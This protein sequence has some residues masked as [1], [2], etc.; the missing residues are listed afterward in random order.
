MSILIKLEGIEKEY[1]SFGIRTKVLKGINLTIRKGE[2][3]SIMGV[4]GSGKTTL[5]NIIGCLDTPTS[6][7]YFFEG[8]DVSDLDDDRLSEIRNEYIGFVF[9]QFYL[10]NYLTVLENVIVPTIYSKNHRENP[11]DRAKELLEKVGLK[12]KLS[13]KPNQLS[14]GQQQRV[15]IAR[16]LIND[17]DLILADEPTGALDSKTASEIMD[18]FKELNREGKTIVVVTHDPKVASIADRIIR[19]EDGKIID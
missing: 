10:I 15:A 14:G 4:S 11:K 2:F 17:P 8:M 5:M 6:G 1:E 19:I 9:Q 12:E 16:A 13:F 7:K 3:V 18:I